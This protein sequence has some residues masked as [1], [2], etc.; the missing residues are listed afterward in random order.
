MVP[1]ENNKIMYYLLQIL[2]YIATL[3]VLILVIKIVLS[4]IQFEKYYAIVWFIVY[5]MAWGVVDI[6]FRYYFK[7]LIYKIQCLYLILM[8]IMSIIL[9]SWKLW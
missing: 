5:F 8:L 7:N 2:S 6:F 3:I 1:S 4:V 9:F